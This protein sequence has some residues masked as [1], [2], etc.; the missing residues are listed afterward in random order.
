MAC[1]GAR[2]DSTRFSLCF[3]RE[4]RTELLP[5]LPSLKTVHRT[6]FLT[7][8]PKGSN[9][10]GHKKKDLANAKSFFLARPRG[11]EP[12]APRTGIWCSIQLSYERVCE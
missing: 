10:L 3:A 5:Q 11:F 4:N 7:L 6:V 8:R 1:F 12:P 2:E 9:P